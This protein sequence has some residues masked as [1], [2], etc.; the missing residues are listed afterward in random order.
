MSSSTKIILENSLGQTVRTFH[1]MPESFELILRLDTGRI[2]ACFDL[3]QLDQQKV[4]YR[5]LA[6]V[7]KSQLAQSAINIESFGTLKLVEDISSFSKSVVL[8]PE[9]NE[10]YNS[11]LAVSTIGH[12]ALVLVILTLGFFFH[13]E[14]EL[15]P[16]EVVIL[17]PQKPKKQ[18]VQ[19]T[20][21]KKIVTVAK[22]VIKKKKLRKSKVKRSRKTRI[23]RTQNLVQRPKRRVK[24]QAKAKIALNQR[25]ALAALGA[26]SAKSKQRGGVNLNKVK[27]SFGSGLGGSGGSG[28]VQ[29]SIYSKGLIAAPTGRGG[30]IKGAGGYG[31]KGK[32]GGQ[33]GYGK[34]A[35][36][37]G[38]SAYFK[39]LTT[40]ALVQGGLDKSQ[41]AAVINRHLGQVRYC[42]EKGLQSKPNLKGRLKMKFTINGN[43]IVS[44]ANIGSS[45]VNDRSVES[46]I[47]KK[48]R[49][50]KFPKPVGNVNVK[51]SYPFV[52]NRVN[53]G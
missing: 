21:K 47:T 46:C 41:V 3:S 17:K 49:S 40:Q 28:G 2:S 29:T 4:P 42:Y 43:G 50:W 37:G 24:K 23:T 44:A 35:L 36:A 16:T 39:P 31:T 38:S 27:T 25:G 30:K 6:S 48:L 34:M 12:I 13:P 52:L 51:V 5:S 7:R 14:K 45:S 22:K 20:P 11:L 9:T 8:R 18:R 15:K 33:A 1:N 19:K 10:K 53:R 32:G 26:I